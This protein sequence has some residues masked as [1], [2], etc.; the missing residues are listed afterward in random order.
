LRPFEYIAAIAVAYCLSAVGERIL[1][2]KSNGVAGWNLSFLVGLSFIAT[3]FF[4]LSL[5]VSTNALNGTAA[6][7]VVVGLWR[8][9]WK[10]PAAREAT[11]AP[12]WALLSKAMLALAIVLALQFTVQNY[13][14]SYHWDG[15]QIWATKARV[16]Y[17]RGGLT[18]ELF[19]P[20]EPVLMALPNCCDPTDRLTPYPQIIPLSE[21]LLSKLRGDFDWQE[22][23]AI[24]PFFFLS[25]LISTFE[26]ARAFVPR[27]PALAACVL[28]A[29]VPAVATRQNVGGYADMPQAALVAGTLA[30]LLRGPQRGGPSYRHAAPWVL[31]GVLLVK[32]EGTILF[33]ITCA[34]IVLVWASQGLNGFAAVLRK[35]A[36]AI[37]L[38]AICLALR[39]LYL[40]WI[41][42]NDVTYG[43]IDSAHLANALS[44]FW[45]IPATCA[46]FM[47]DLPEWGLFWPVFFLALPIVFWKGGRREIALAGGTLAALAAYTSI[48]YFT[49][50]EFH[51]HIAQAYSR[52]LSQLAPAA[53]VLT[54]IAYWYGVR[55]KLADLSPGEG[56]VQS[57]GPSSIPDW[58]AIAAV[59]S[60]VL[61]GFF[62]RSFQAAATAPPTMKIPAGSPAGSKQEP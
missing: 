47:F 6:A 3:F 45:Q 44:R 18:R 52:L 25:L 31:G 32:N 23:K 24:F 9:F 35:Y 53:A 20:Q 26:A 27:G 49:N 33:G 13:R 62:L 55:G 58:I 21:A 39:M 60:I 10:Q 28:L 19:R 30:S 38:V 50:W 8:P 42:L 17:E 11:V 48:F 15:Y 1:G 51:L 36:G 34:A 37:A 61:G 56:S 12:G 22:V 46:R 43:P 40:R 41:H 2:R 59:V 14:S 4:P 29:L 5:I 16:L 7:L 57:Q 54:T